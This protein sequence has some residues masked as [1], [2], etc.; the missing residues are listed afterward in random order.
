MTPF[1]VSSHIPSLGK[2]ITCSLIL[3]DR[4]IK[5]GTVVNDHVVKI[6]AKAFRVLT[7]SA[8]ERQEAL[9]QRVANFPFP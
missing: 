4:R 3:A 6:S 8:D 9:H 5:S 1:E 2:F 7:T